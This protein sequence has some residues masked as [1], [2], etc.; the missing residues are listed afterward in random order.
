MENKNE[1]INNIEQVQQQ[2]T[3]PVQK[4]LNQHLPPGKTIILIIALVLITIGLVYLA[5]SSSVIKD[6][7]QQTTITKDS[8]AYAQTEIRFAETPYET[9]NEV[10]LAKEYNLDAN[11]TTGN[12]KVTAV[13]FELTYDPKALSNVDIKLGSLNKEWTEL[14][15][16]ID[17]VNGTITYAVGI[18]LGQRGISGEGSI[19]TLTFTKAYGFTGET[20]IRFQPKAQATAEGIAKS[21]LRKTVN[22]SFTFPEET[23]Q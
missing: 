12:N 18:A 11:I 20:K 8:L 22:A 19:A 14:I 6:N 1:Q 10:T 2:A 13:Q 15:K 21:V 7:K 3:Q 17:P 16:K 5:V 23:T 4:K 9:T